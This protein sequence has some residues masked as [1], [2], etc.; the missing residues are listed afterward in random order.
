MFLNFS[1]N[2]S[3]FLVLFT[4]GLFWSIPTHAIDFFRNES[5]SDIGNWHYGIGS[6]WNSSG[7]LNIGSGPGGGG[8][9]WSGT[10]PIN[11]VTIFASSDN[12]NTYNNCALMLTYWR[13]GNTFQF[14]LVSSTIPAGIA[15]GGILYS[16]DFDV[17]SVTTTLIFSQIS[18]FGWR[19]VNAPGETCN[20]D[21]DDHD[22]E[23]DFLGLNMGT[24][25]SYTDPASGATIT[26]M[27]LTKGGDPTF[28]FMPAIW[29]ETVSSTV[30]GGGLNPPLLSSVE[31]YPIP[32]NNQC[33]LANWSVRGEVGTIDEDYW[34]NY[35][36][37]VAYGTSPVFTNQDESPLL[38]GSGTIFPGATANMPAKYLQAPFI[39]TTTE[40]FARAYICNSLNFED[41]DFRT[42]NPNQLASSPL[43]SFTIDPSLCGGGVATQQNTTSTVATQST[44]TTEFCEENEGGVTGFF[45]RVF[46]FLFTVDQSVLN[47]FGDLKDDISERPPFGYISVYAGV[48]ENVSS[49]TSTTST[50]SGVGF[51]FSEWSDLDFWDYIRTPLG[52]IC[53]IA[54]GW[55]I[56][57]RFKHFSLHG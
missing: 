53:W 57:Y 33:Q 47:R 40:I 26:N 3:I 13:P 21:P 27:N 43:Y 25:T 5:F 36:V 1:R 15:G 20:A 34:N 55:Y 51:Q 11:S 18:G 30:E 23:I 41:C 19:F 14:D 28:R 10:S 12:P 2:T 45:C 54:F 6:G 38:W 50:W 39:T 7:Q 48:W 22:R 52:W 31:L 17:Q 35:R 9:P 24:T 16:I 42:A 32:E 44:N 46:G 37:V 4:A 29:I 56:Y 49:A 8:A